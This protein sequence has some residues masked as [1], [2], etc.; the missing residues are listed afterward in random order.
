ME[1]KRRRR[2]SKEQLDAELSAY[3]EAVQKR[4]NEMPP[5]CRSA[6]LKA[7]RGKSPAAAIKAQCL[8]CVGWDR[9][10][11]RL[12]TCPACSLYPYRPFK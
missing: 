1:R 5:S 7:M 3:P 4:H 6:Y 11:V 12:C 8:E 9:N 2:K 10:E